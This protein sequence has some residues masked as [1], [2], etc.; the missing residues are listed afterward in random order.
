MFKAEE[1]LEKVGWA[2]DCEEL[3]M[4]MV[5]HLGGH[6]WCEALPGDEAILLFNEVE[7]LLRLGKKMGQEEVRANIWQNVTGQFGFPQ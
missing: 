1:F 3:I 5:D 4:A 7:W 2:E 6:D